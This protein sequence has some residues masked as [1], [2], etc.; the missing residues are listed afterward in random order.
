MNQPTIVRLVAASLAAVFVLCA[1]SPQ[2]PSAMPA[3]S[4]AG[5]HAVEIVATVPADSP[6]VYVSGNLP[7]LGPWDPAG[8]A[9]TGTGATRRATLIVPHG[10]ALQYKIT[11]GSWEREG[12]GPSGTVMPAFGAQ[13][14]EPVSLTASIEGFRVDPRVHIDNWQGAGVEGRLEYWL[15][16]NSPL[17]EVDRHIVVWLPPAYDANPD[18]R[19]EVIYMHDGQNLFDPRI[20]YTGVDWGVDEAAMRGERAGKYDA[21]IIVGIWNTSRRLYEYSPWHD[22]ATYA[23]FV[24]EELKPK[25]DAGFRTLTGP[26][27]TYTMGS[28]MGGLISMYLVQNYPQTFGACGCVSTH[29]SWSPQMIE[30]FMGR[31]PSKAEP[32]PYLIQDIQAGARMPK[33]VRLYFD[34]GTEGLDAAYG[35]PHDA[36]SAWLNGQGFADGADYKIVKFEGAGHN[37]AAWRERVGEQLDWLLAP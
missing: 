7:T 32:T 27:H 5:E 26:E 18:K 6:T 33:G 8:L 35:A 23:Q 31:D 36:L 13:V 19:F 14:T 11:A 2:K 34:Y 10:H 16:Y 17:L 24:V 30:W 15:D 12:L 29:V 21:P 28:S 22:G 1:C 4:E 37:E 3:A 20:A 9:M 25:I